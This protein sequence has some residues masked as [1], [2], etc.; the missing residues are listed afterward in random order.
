M[1]VIS[2]VI[3]KVFAACAVAAATTTAAAAASKRYRCVSAPTETSRDGL[4]YAHEI[5][6]EVKNHKK[7]TFYLI[8]LITYFH[9]YIRVHTYSRIHTYVQSLRLRVAQRARNNNE[10][11][12]PQSRATF[13]ATP[14]VPTAS[15][16][17]STSNNCR[18]PTKVALVL[19]ST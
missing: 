13:A 9:I 18:Q 19:V 3:V 4:W 10:P 2:V 15:R 7:C 11:S 14:Q 5:E 8:H 16:R 1:Y 6:K 12:Y 17:L